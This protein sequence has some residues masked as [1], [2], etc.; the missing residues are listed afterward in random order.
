MESSYVEDEG[1]FYSVNLSLKE[2]AT[3]KPVFLAI[4]DFKLMINVGKEQLKNGILDINR[5]KK[6]S[7]GYPI[8]YY[9]KGNDKIILD[10]MHRLMKYYL[11]YYN[12]ENAVYPNIPCVKITR[13]KLKKCEIKNHQ[14]KVIKKWK[15]KVSN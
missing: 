2:T 3:T 4:D 7:L 12:K 14:Q 9:Q 5:I 8:I 13:D 1:V 10:G 15:I 6:A 11:Y